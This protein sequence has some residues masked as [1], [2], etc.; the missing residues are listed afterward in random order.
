MNG[1]AVRNVTRAHWIR[2]NDTSR[3]PG[4]YLFLATVQRQATVRRG[5]VHRWR[6]A[7]TRYVTKSHHNGTWRDPVAFD[8]ADPGALWR[9]VGALTRKGSRVVVVAHDLGVVLRA[10]QAF[11]ILPTLG[12]T[13]RMARLDRGAALAIWRRDGATLV[14]VDALAWFAVPLDELAGMVGHDRARLPSR[15]D[16]TVGWVERCRGDALILERAWMR[17]MEWVRT[18][19]LGNWRPTASGQVFQAWR[20][21]FM[22]HGVLAHDDTEA[23]D[24]ERRAA[25][26]GRC[27]AWRHGRLEGAGWYEWDFRAAYCSIAAE[28]MVPVALEGSTARMAWRRWDRLE[29]DRALLADCR[30]TTAVPVV[31][32]QGAHGIV[33]PTGT[34]HTTLWDVEVRAALDAGADVHLGRVWIYRQAYALRR[35]ARWIM[36]LMD[37][38]GAHGDPLVALI[39]KG[40]SRSIVG[41]FAARWPEWTEWGTA[42]FDDCRSMR[43]I[44]TRNGTTS[45]ALHLGRQVVTEG[46]LK[47]APDSAPQVT[48][49]ITAAARVRLWRLMESVGLEHLAYVDTDSVIVDATA[50]AALLRSAPPGLRLKGTYRDLVVLGPRQ[51]VVNYRPRIAGVPR[52]AVSEDGDRWRSE[53]WRTVRTALREGSPDSVLVRERVQRV[54]G[55]D[56]RRVHLD[57]G[58]T[59]S[60]TIGGG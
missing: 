2:S 36:D 30:V 3:M 19:D 37:D 34:F 31:P 56:H 24:A 48:S 43:I 47:D 29:G 11:T 42:P 27:E 4:A 41:R 13:L 46:A 18:N 49:Y 25:W 21:R 51:M 10:S 14:M 44:D 22:D 9:H 23:R 50:H 33:W 60:V 58:A 16:D 40:W 53:A 35:V 20:H 17:V 15:E 39:A 8:H 52:D 7:S 59:G 6:M 57:G 32:A 5:V 12:W 38:Q 1:P 26:A 45:E 28:S 55:I 54:A